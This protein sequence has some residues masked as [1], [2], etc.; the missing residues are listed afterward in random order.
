MKKELLHSS[1]EL[2]DYINQVGFLP[3]L[4]MGLGWSA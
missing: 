2:I 3:L 1:L 4:S